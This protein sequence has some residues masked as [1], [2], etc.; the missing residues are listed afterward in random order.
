MA[1]ASNSLKLVS[2]YDT[3]GPDVVEYCIN[4]AETQV[5][6]ASSVHLP[7]LLRLH[8]QC[9]G[10]RV[11]VS[12]D[13]WDDIEAR[14]TQPSPKTRDLLKKWASDLGILMLDIDEVQEMGKA[15]NH[16][17][18]PPTADTIGAIC[19]TSGTTGMPK[20]AILTHRLLASSALSSLHGAAMKNEDSILYSFLPLSHIYERF[21]ED[22]ALALGAPIGFSCGDNLRI[23]EDIQILQPNTLCLV[24]RVLN[25]FYTAI[26]SATL[27]LPGVK[28]VL[29]RKA[30]AAKLHNLR[31]NGTYTH[32][33][34][35]RILFKKVRALLG[36][37]VETIGSGS[38]PIAPEV[39]EFL[40]IMFSCSVV[41]GYGLTETGASVHFFLLT[42]ADICGQVATLFA[43]S[44]RITVS[45]FYLFI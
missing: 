40:K 10:M 33:V 44:R 8:K 29:I 19:Y 34:Y 25:R 38:A 1:C 17:F 18:N 2:L 20:G 12:V 7:A 3:L 9:P 37:K 16:P 21:C 42:R 5:V 14:K 6:F 22:V 26:K 43:A 4:H 24:P 36:G 28:G 35:D 32:A 30:Y 31:T 45:C 11:L 41:E 13:R 23:L 27:D 15:A 39:L